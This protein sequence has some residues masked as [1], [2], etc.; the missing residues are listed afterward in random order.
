MCQKRNHWRDGVWTRRKLDFAVVV[1]GHVES[2]SAC[3]WWNEPGLI[4]IAKMCARVDGTFEV[5]VEKCF[6]LVFVSGKMIQIHTFCEI[7]EFPGGTVLANI[8]FGEV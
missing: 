6:G 8:G 4:E 7:D 2:I 1:T 3:L 5:Q